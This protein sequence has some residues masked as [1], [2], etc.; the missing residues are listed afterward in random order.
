MKEEFMC[1]INFPKYEIGNKGNIISYKRNKPV[2]SNPKI[3]RDGYGELRIRD[4]KHK[5]K[6]IKVHRL[7]LMAFNPISDYKDMQINHIDGNKMN[8]DID[9]L[10]WCTSSE[11]MKHSFRTLRKAS[12]LSTKERTIKVHLKQRK[13]PNKVIEIDSLYKAGKYLNKS[14]GSINSFYYRKNKVNGKFFV[15]DNEYLIKFIPNKQPIRYILTDKN[16]KVEEFF[17]AEAVSV[18][19]NLSRVAIRN[20][21]DKK[22]K[23]SII[24]KKGFKLEEYREDVETI[25]R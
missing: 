2:K 19:L 5:R 23:N 11:N 14:T 20:Y 17:S 7:V 12:K 24:T 3:D 6:Y 13:F 18:R 16:N 21:L 15:Y 22:V 1:L 25:E 10:H 9:N 8:N 4:I